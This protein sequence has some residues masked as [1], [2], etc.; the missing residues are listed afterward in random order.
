MGLGVI[1]LFFIIFLLFKFV[2][3]LSEAVEAL[4]DGG[5]GG[6]K[7]L[8]YIADGEAAE[9]QVDQRTL[10]WLEVVDDAEVVGRRLVDLLGYGVVHPV[11]EG[12]KTGLTGVAAY[13]VD[14]NVE[15]YAVHPRVGGAA[16]FE[17]GP[18]LPEGADNL[19]IEVADAVG[20]AVGEVEAYLEYGALAA[21]KHIEKGTLFV[22]AD[23]MRAEQGK[24]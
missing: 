15:G 22:V 5:L 17:L 23:G 12:H 21:A 6:G 3:F 10:V 2:D 19:L 11:L 8:C 13:L 20:P 1:S 7:Y 9:P 4:L 16:A 14:G 24:Q 18:R